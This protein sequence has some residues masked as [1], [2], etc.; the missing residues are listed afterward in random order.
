M[1]CDLKFIVAFFII[2]I[3]I[4]CGHDQGQSSIAVAPSTIIGR[5]TLNRPIEAYSF[6][7]GPHVYV[8]VS[9]IHGGYEWN[10]ALMAKKMIDTFGVD[11]R[12]IPEDVTLKIVPI[13]NPDGF[14]HAD[15]F[16]EMS[17]NNEAQIMEKWNDMKLTLSAAQIINGRTNGRQVDLNRNFDCNWQPKGYMGSLQLSAG[18]EPASEAETKGVTTWLKSLKNLRGVV[19]Y[20]SQAG[21]VYPGFCGRQRVL[22][23]DLFG[24]F[25]AAASALPTAAPYRFD[26]TQEFDAYPVTGDASDWVVNELKVP[27]LTVE[28]KTKNQ[29]EFDANIKAVLSMLQCYHPAV[30]YLQTLQQSKALAEQCQVGSLPGPILGLK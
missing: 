29:I 22:A 6:G 3:F 7:N 11:S 9:A 1:Y 4:G 2:N 13:M 18:T 28:L 5:S 15:Y 30:Q 25:Y 21:Q 17:L 12:R 14:Y 8:L 23:A 20:H 19:F 27:A 10:T 24:Q 16:S 26:A